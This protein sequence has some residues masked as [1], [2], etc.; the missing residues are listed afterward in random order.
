MGLDQ[1][2]TEEGSEHHH[3]TGLKV[4]SPREKGRGRPRNTW[5]RSVEDE[6]SN[7]K[8]DTVGT[9]LLRW[10]KTE[11]DGE[12]LSVAYALHESEKA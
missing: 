9:H 5:R 12:G 1:K 2:C 10:H 7:S 6:M 3:T 8:Q 11:S 4:E